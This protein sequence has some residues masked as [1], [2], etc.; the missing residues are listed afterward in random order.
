MEH[1]R[2]VLVV[3]EAHVAVVMLGVH[4]LRF[5]EPLD[6]AVLAHELVNVRGRAMLGDVE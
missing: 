4:A 3:R 2:A 1:E 6:V 5:L